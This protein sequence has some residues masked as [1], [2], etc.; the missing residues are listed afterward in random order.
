MVLPKYRLLGSILSSIPEASETRLGCS[1]VDHEGMPMVS[2]KRS[3]TTR[4]RV[5]VCGQ[6]LRMQFGKLNVFWKSHVCA[7]WDRQIKDS[8]LAGQLSSKK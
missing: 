5:G 6:S 7:C 4:M 1:C 2:G 8:D 3:S